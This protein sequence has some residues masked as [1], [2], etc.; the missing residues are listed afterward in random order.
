LTRAALATDA[1]ERE[2]ALSEHSDIFEALA[3]RDHLI[4]SGREL[5]TTTGGRDF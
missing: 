2:R 4:R 5:I 3:A 1:E